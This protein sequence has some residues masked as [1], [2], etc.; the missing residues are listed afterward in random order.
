MRKENFQRSSDAKGAH[1]SML[2]SPKYAKSCSFAI[3][4]HSFA[5]Y[6]SGHRYLRLVILV[7][8]LHLTHKF[9]K[10]CCRP[11]R[12]TW[13]NIKARPFC[14][15]TKKYFLTLCDRLMERK[16]HVI[17]HL[18]L[19]ILLWLF[20]LEIFL[21]KS[22]KEIL[23]LSFFEMSWFRSGKEPSLLKIR[24]STVEGNLWAPKLSMHQ[25]YVT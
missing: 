1:F 3:K 6:K 12:P 16:F 18:L 9:R 21:A 2:I 8:L 23:D 13:V 19:K 5:C 25:P 17:R 24:Q 20:C 10:S 15:N 7:T 11:S 22:K 4:D 14:R